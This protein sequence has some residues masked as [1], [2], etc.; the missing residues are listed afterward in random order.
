[1]K[2][3]TIIFTFIAALLV[4]PALIAQEGA[5]DP[6]PVG[7][8]AFFNAA[9]CPA[10]W[11]LDDAL[12]GRTVVP[13][14]SKAGTT[15]GQ[16]LQSGEN[17]KHTHSVIAQV[18]INDTSYISAGGFDRNLGT[19]G[20]YS[21]S[22]EFEGASS[23]T[24]YV[25]MLACRKTSAPAGG[26]PPRDVITFAESSEC[27]SEWTLA[28]AIIGRYLVGLPQAGTPNMTF[29]GNPLTAGET[30]IHKHAITG[31]SSFTLETEPVGVGS[32]CC[33]NGFAKQGT[34]SYAGSSTSASAGLPYINLRPC[35]PR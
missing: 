17:R 34:Y 28:T 7:A 31:V 15:S 33:L 12:T 25:Q 35:S 13:M 32:G 16:P 30:R 18:T 9:Q 3:N 19:A 10:G 23:N 20:T 26:P 4:A 2:H 21:L 24:P 22:G 1:M 5:G 11:S 29:G 6:Y 8:I 27:A 14:D